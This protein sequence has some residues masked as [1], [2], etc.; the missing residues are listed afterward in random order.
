MLKFKYEASQWDK[1]TFYE[2]KTTGITNGTDNR[3][4]TFEGKSNL[5]LV[6]NLIFAVYNAKAYDELSLSTYFLKESTG[7]VGQYFAG[8][9]NDSTAAGINR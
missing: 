1:F 4:S 7:C 5:R 2:F 8:Q 6:D 3:V 9:G